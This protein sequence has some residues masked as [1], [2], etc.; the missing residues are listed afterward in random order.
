MRNILNRL[1]VAAECRKGLVGM[2]IVRQ[3]SG[4]NGGTCPAVYETDQGTYLVQ[5]AVVTDDD[6]LAALRLP[7]G[8]T[9]VE[10]P[11]EILLGA[12]G[13]GQEG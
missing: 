1:A 5:G 12:R 6:A 10:V 13:G 2:R 8:E 7:P 9:V 11:A 3:V 4:C